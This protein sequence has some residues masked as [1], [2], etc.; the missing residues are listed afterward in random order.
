MQIKSEMTELNP[1]DLEPMPVDEMRVAQLMEQITIAGVITQP[2]SV[3]MDAGGKVHVIDGFHRSEAARRLLMPSIKVHLIECDEKHFWDLRISATTE[4]KS[5]ANDRLHMWMLDAWNLTEWAKLTDSSFA[6]T[7]YNV[8]FMLYN[9][10]RN[11]A[12]TKD[13]KA[14]IGW[15]AERAKIWGKD[16]REIARIILEKS[17]LFVQ[18]TR[19]LEMAVQKELTYEQYAKAVRMVDSKAKSE[20]I[21]DRDIRIVLDRAIRDEA[22][23]LSEIRA[24]QAKPKPQKPVVDAPQPTTELPSQPQPQPIKGDQAADRVL[25]LKS[26]VQSVGDLIDTGETITEALH[27][28]PGLDTQIAQIIDAMNLFVEWVSDDY[29]WNIASLREENAKLKQEI[30]DLKRKAERGPVIVPASALAQSSSDYRY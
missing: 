7:A 1:I 22:K 25:K 6:S 18:Y 20:G 28:K 4:H 11:P 8:Y 23:P 3:W 5:V 14:L 2:V 9:Q 12:L 17:G 21:S 27:A 26:V 13:E 29:K 16:V 30:V 24:E 19:L 10:L 15:F